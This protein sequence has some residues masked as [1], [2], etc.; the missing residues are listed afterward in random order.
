MGVRALRNVLGSGLR[1]ARAAQARKSWAA[2]DAQAANM[3]CSFVEITWVYLSISH[4]AATTGAHVLSGNLQ[5]G[6]GTCA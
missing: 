5:D 6:P 2:R 4:S 3:Y 1:E